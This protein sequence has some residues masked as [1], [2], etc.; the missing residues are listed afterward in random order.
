MTV[1]AEA[2]SRRD[3]WRR[4]A[5]GLAALI[6]F[7]VLFLAL[8]AFQG[9]FYYSRHIK[10]AADIQNIG[11]QLKLYRSMNGFFPTT[12]QGLHALVEEPASEP[13]PPRWYQLYRETPL[14]P[15]RS[16]YIYRCPGI[17]HP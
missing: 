15:W 10:V 8:P 16:P 9:E 2:S 12:A 5:V 17:K 14:D 4:V 7:L 3:Y 11:T 1:T 13:R 6:A